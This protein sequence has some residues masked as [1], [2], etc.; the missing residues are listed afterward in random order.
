MGF[1]SFCGSLVIATAIYAAGGSE[2]VDQA[3][4]RLEQQTARISAALRVE[5]RMRAAQSLAERHPDLAR[6]FVNLAVQEIRADK[7]L[8]VSFAVLQ[9]FAMAAP[10]E[11][12]A[13]LPYLPPQQ[14]S[15]MT[16]ALAQ[17]NRIDEALAL[18]RQSL[19]QGDLQINVASTLIGRLAKKDPAEAGKLFQELLTAA[20]LETLDPPN[21]YRLLDCAKAVLPV[22]AG[23]A[24]DACERIAV[25]ASAPDYGAKAV[26]V[27]TASF[28]VGTETINTTNSRDTLLVASGSR[29]R[30]WA[31][32]RFD[33]RKALF[34][35]WNL[36]GKL[37]VKAMSYQN[38]N[39]AQPKKAFL[40]TSAIS[41][42]FGQIRG[43]PTDAD[44]ARLVIQI[45]R[46]IRALPE[47]A[48]RVSLASSLAGRVTEG[49]L[50]KEA[51]SAVGDLLA[52]ALQGAPASSCDPYLELASLVRFE[53]L[54]A[55]KSDPN[56]DAADTL[57][58]LQEQL[59]QEDGFTLTGLDGKTYSLA[60]L[61][62]HV[63]LLNFWATWCPPCRKEMPDMEK[64]YQRLQ[65]KGLIVLA[66]SDEERE[67]VA[68]FEQKEKYTF[69]ILLDADRK[70]AGAFN[71]GGIPQSFLFDRE[72]KLVAHAIDMRTERQFLEML[73][74][75]GM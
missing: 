64:L 15:N 60:A 67:T 72:G 30:E 36:T 49:D 24:V 66:A 53:H 17:A 14:K 5:F 28:Q 46:D 29:L 45:A 50:G 42:Q 22:A 37:S 65:S 51:L 43:L 59:H 38:V 26:T 11:G 32:A 69:P 62:G 47:G 52:Q 2:S 39:A 71:V 75:A 31:P 56:L 54:P 12:I 73:K 41:Q 13:L 8:R 10:P 25:A 48:V 70:V 21:A 16:Q 3:S 44:R 6:K 20:H 23:P 33:E 9:A 34:E 19:A 58:A 18:Y 57:L 68:N 63:V 40:D 1:R 7:E 61:R 27:M 55:P 35:R 74:L 4:A